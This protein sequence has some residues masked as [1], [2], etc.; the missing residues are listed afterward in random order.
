MT[1]TRA[2]TPG[3]F[4][5][6]TGLGRLA[7]KRAA[8]AEASHPPIGEIVMVDGRRVHVHC[9]GSGRPLILLHGAGGNLRDFTF[10]L[11]GRMA[12]TNTVYAFD[13]PGHG[14]TDTLHNH[15]ESP[16]EQAE[17]LHKAAIA[18]G[19]PD[20]LICGFSLGGVVALAWALAEPGF[21][22]GLLLLGAVSHPWP[23]GVGL[24]YTLAANTITSPFLVPLVAAF[25]PETLVRNTLTSVFQPNQPPEGY[26]DYIGAGL[27]LRAH[28]I[29]AN[30][31]QVARLRPHVVE[32]AK[33]YAELN[34]P[35][36][37]LHGVEDRSVYAALHAA[38]LS[39][40]APNSRYTLLPGVGHSPHHHAKP[41]VLAALARLN[42]LRG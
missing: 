7:A 11:A 18:L 14:Y 29:R 1:E 22:R 13:R 31:R 2:Y 42:T 25:P 28:S 5:A 9:Q 23:G 12:R 24:T 21:V 10:D 39:R 6:L 15:G 37:I 8:M 20:A 36:E 17:M 41:E 3:S 4:A 19:I 34:I 33:R 30:A 26:L 35:V 16:K 40:V 27:S 32:M 38:N